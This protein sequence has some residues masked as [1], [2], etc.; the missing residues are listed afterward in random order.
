MPVGLLEPPVGFTTEELDTQNEA[1]EELLTTMGGFTPVYKELLSHDD[2]WRRVISKVV[3]DEP[4]RMF[5]ARYFDGDEALTY[6][7]AERM[8]DQVPAFM[9]LCDTRDKPRERP[10]SPAPFVDFAWH[11]WILHT[12][13]YANFCSTQLTRGFLHHNPYN[14]GFDYAAEEAFPSRY[15]RAVAGMYLRELPVDP[16]LWRIMPVD[17]PTGD[18]GDCC[19][20]C[21]D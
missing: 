2:T 14:D 5:A 8:L 12:R 4:V 17:C 9:F 19:E 1:V 7:L 13:L 16:P 11:N 18:S 3:K 21:S 20:A 15:R 6:A 10:F